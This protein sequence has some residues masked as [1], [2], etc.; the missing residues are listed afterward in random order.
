MRR[1]WSVVLAVIVGVASVGVGE[2]AFAASSVTL[3]SK[4]F[5]DVAPGRVFHD[6]ISWLANEGIS[7]GWDVGGGAFEFRPMSS[8]ARDAMAAFLYRL[9]GSPS[10]TPPPVSVF[11]DVPTDYPYY[12]QISW[13]ASTGVSTGWSVGGGMFEFRPQAAVARDSMA[14]FMYRFAKTVLKRD[15]T[16]FVTPSMSPFTDVPMDYPFY[17][18]ITWLASTGVTTGW[19]ASDGTAKYRP[20]D[21]VT[22]DA[23]AAFMYRLSSTS[24]PVDSSDP[25]AGSIVVAPNAVVV[26][27]SQANQLTVSGSAIEVPKGADLKDVTPG[28]VLV[29]GAS[30]NTPEGL[31]T[32]VESVTTR[33]DGTLSLQ[34]NSAQLTDVITQTD[35]PISV[36]MT[37]VSAAFTPAQG[38]SETVAPSTRGVSKSISKKF[39]WSKTY[40]VKGETSSGALSGQGIVDVSLSAT[41]ALRADLTLDV[42]LTGVKEAGVTVT[43]SVS[44]EDVITADGAFKG[45]VTAPVGAISAVF[46]VQVGPVPV[47]ITTDSNL[48]ATVAVSG[49]ARA[50][51]AASGTVSSQHG[52]SYKSGSFSLIN[53]KPTL[54]S[55][56]TD[57]K[58]TANVSTRASLDLDASVKLYGIAGITFGVGP[59][60]TATITSNTA[61]GA[62]IWDCPATF[63]VHTQVGVIA[64]LSI[65]GFSLPKWDETIT[66][67]W[68]LWTKQ[69]CPKGQAP[70]QPNTQP[71]SI[72]TTSLPTATLGQAYAAQME[73]TGGAK[74]YIWSATGLPQ[75]LSIDTNT[76][77][78]AGTPTTATAATPTITVTDATTAT[79]ATSLTFNTTATTAFSFPDE[80]L[81]KCVTDALGIPAGSQISA[82]Q[83]QTLTTLDCGGGMGIQDL[84]GI[85]NLSNLMDLDVSQSQ[86]IV[87]ISPL[88]KLEELET[89]NL[90]WNKISDPSPLSG[91]TNL[92][93]LNLG[94]NDISDISALV[95][96]KNVTTL[97]LADNRITDISP[98]SQLR[99]AEV[100]GLSSNQVSDLTPLAGLQSLTTLSL[101]FNPIESLTP[102][103]SL[104]GLNI[105]GL[106][107]TGLTD[108]SPLSNLV[109]LELLQIHNNKISDIRPL[110]SLKSL[111]SLTIKNN[112]ISDLRPL[113]GLTD[114]EYLDARDQMATID[115]GKIKSGGSITF[116]AAINAN[117]AYYAPSCIDCTF[118][119]VSGDVTFANMDGAQEAYAAFGDWVTIGEASFG[120][121]V[122][123]VGIYVKYSIG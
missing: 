121:N 113:G 103:S 49:N 27:D 14:A 17:V 20:L 37:P 38:A 118:D 73:A 85:E 42:G 4:S 120:P 123:S 84:S 77:T 62:A 60:S 52:F 99:K 7:T 101:D 111:T 40:A 57:V 66:G 50:T 70:E 25:D 23:M 2:G 8:T 67:D 79:F 110:S 55:G 115:V 97:D 96:L 69:M 32:R 31:L 1:F 92:R 30:S 34:T 94:Q 6:E 48:N 56:Q 78:I 102:I 112:Q 104:T 68:N 9:A 90:T 80:N 106:S 107:Y 86:K 108:I 5:V 61:N 39:T 10:Y 81:Q 100:I 109:N 11:T 89:L 87:D 41:A 75:G 72:V 63:G 82:T 83:A 46:T 119:P 35:Q 93:I 88:A 53:T 114:L 15:V 24:Q 12:L 13:L 54:T 18:E 33:S 64:Q 22:R 3:E 65:W 117:G 59:Y 91:L 122:F 45:S 36:E 76:G 71:L 44:T 28:D 95:D 51:V 29:A 26:S 47:V 116:K 58:V 98:L 21:E 16:S 105:L 74:P 43:P 19:N